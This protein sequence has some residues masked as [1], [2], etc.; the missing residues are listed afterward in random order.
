MV[1]VK[2]RGVRIPRNNKRRSKSR[3]KKINTENEENVLPWKRRL[4]LVMQNVLSLRRDGIAVRLFDNV[5]NHLRETIKDLKEIDTS[6]NAQ[7]DDMVETLSDS[8]DYFVDKADTLSF[9]TVNVSPF[10]LFDAIAAGLIFKEDDAARLRNADERDAWVGSLL[11]KVGQNLERLN[12]KRGYFDGT[13]GKGSGVVFVEMARILQGGGGANVVVSRN[14]YNWRT[15]LERVLAEVNR[16]S[17]P[18]DPLINFIYQNVKERLNRTIGVLKS[19]SEN[20]LA[21][22]E[23]WKLIYAN[24]KKR[25]IAFES[26]TRAPTISRMFLALSSGLRVIG[27]E[28]EWISIPDSERE[29]KME[30]VLKNLG[31]HLRKLDT[32]YYESF[33]SPGSG[34]IM[35]GITDILYNI[36]K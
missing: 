2:Q 20:D 30:R 7:W 1:G 15:A 8:M 3:E 32:K 5:A 11:S 28:D 36:G 31:E 14:S 12:A 22:D 4:E 16:M 24:L 17:P 9:L 26:L 34:M 27:S 21:D 29:N 23:K 35:E 13:I 19:M 18:D 6:D 33:L 25:M 10:Y